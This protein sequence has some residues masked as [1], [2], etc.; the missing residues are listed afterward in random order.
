MGNR[1]RTTSIHILDDDS[2]L[3]VFYLYQPFL[4]G[5][6]E[7]DNARLLG[8]SKPWVRGRWWYR[9][10]HVCRRWRN[11]ILGSASYL[12]VTLVCTKGTPVADM[13]AHSPPL[14]LVI[15][16]RSRVITAEDEEGIILALKQRDRVR[17][18][19]LRVSLQKFI[20]AMDEEYPIL[21]YLI[22]ALPIGNVRT[23][24]ILPRTLQAPHL[25]LLMLRGFAIPIGS[26]LLTTAVGLVTLDLHIIHPS[27]YFH[28]N[29]LRQWISLTP[30]LESLQI[31]FKF[32]IPD[33]DIE[34]KLEAPIIES[35]TLPNLLR[36][37]FRGVGTYLEALVHRITTPRLEKL[38]IEFFN[39]PTSRC[40]IP[41]LLQF[42][43]TTK[44]Q[45]FDSARFK[46]TD[47]FVEVAVYLHERKFTKC[48][49]AI[50]VYSWH[51]DWQFSSAV[52]ISNSLSQVF[53]V[54]EHL[55]FRHEEHN[56]SSDEHN[57][58]DHT[59]W[60][61]F[62]RPFR[63]VKTLHIDNGLVKDFSRCLQLEDGELPLELLPELQKLMYSGSGDTG[64][65]LAFTSFIDA[66]QNA[67][68]P[69]TLV[70]S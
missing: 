34:R 37:W 54:V 67:G 15:D 69:V 62:L 63:N 57:T 12:D 4:L 58:V 44:N 45:R 40:S 50:T 48:A 36:F 11:I 27:T 35:V 46:F 10:A 49:L 20:V 51:L 60:R 41:R 64:V 66:R 18:V 39:Q 68:L 55:T 28:P 30:Q 56:R 23:I 19:R 70:R 7:D 17:R 29:T 9:L 33:R 1:L 21:E 26:R 65:S 16:Y 13:L 5:E 47:K 43:N 22:I 14:P 6:D 42:M 3:H 32:Y 24:L 38:R 8:G 53:S 61:K 2:L 25:R 52:Q 59:E 31:Y